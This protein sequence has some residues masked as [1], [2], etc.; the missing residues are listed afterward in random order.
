MSNNKRPPAHMS[1]IVKAASGP[2]PHLNILPYTPSSLLLGQAV[3]GLCLITGAC[4]SHW[5]SHVSAC[6]YA[7]NLDF[8]GRWVQPC[9]L[10]GG[11]GECLFQANGTVVW[12]CARLGSAG[13]GG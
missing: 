11:V 7:W 8:S 12:G 6:A 9:Q 1:A 4:L 2:L 13:I 3:R 5:L 10:F